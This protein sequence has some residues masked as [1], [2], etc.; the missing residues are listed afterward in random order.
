MK[1]SIQLSPKQKKILRFA[2]VPAFYFVALFFFVRLTF[3]YDTLKARILTEYNLSQTEKRLE[4]EE[5]SGSG[6]FGIEAEGV[7]LSEVTT[8]L[9]DGKPATPVSLYLDSVSVGASLLSYIF[10]TLSVAFDAELGGGELNGTFLQGTE[11]SRLTLHGSTIDISGLTMLS[12]GVG[13]PMGGELSGEVELFLPEGQMSKAEGKFD[14][15]ILGL[16]VGD[17]KAKVRGT[18]ALPKLNA[19]NLTLK[20]EAVEGRLEISEFSTDGPDFKMDA[21]GKLRLRE[22]FDKSTTNIDVRFSFKEAYTTKSDMTKSLFGA[23]DS[24]IP[25]L[26]DMDPSVRA[27]KQEDGSYGWTVSGLLSKPSFRPQRA[28]T[29]ARSPDAAKKKK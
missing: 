20:A 3:P 1:I 9:V 12:A 14:L 24:K 25:G 11:E 19:G 7:R 4:I 10:G 16:A 17:G 6:L 26:F 18:I 28:R 2:G 5:L 29:T 8:E 15:S 13:L 21:E 27:A 23:P 22:P